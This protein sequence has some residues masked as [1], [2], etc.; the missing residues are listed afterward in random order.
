MRSPFQLLL[1]MLAATSVL[2]DSFSLPP[3]QIVTAHTTRSTVLNLVPEQGK[4]LVAA[5]TAASVKKEAAATTS[6]IHDD[7]NKKPGVAFV[8]SSIFSI[9][10]AILGRHPA[11]ALVDVPREQLPRDRRHEDVVLYPV[12][13]FRFVKGATGMSSNV[14]PTISKPACQLLHVPNQELYGWFTPACPLD[15]IYS[16]TYCNEPPKLMECK[17]K[18]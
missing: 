15:N 11:A 5:F 8:L 7:D 4:Q 14:L 9:P 6:T 3:H 2:I 17:P 13:G 16:D 1:L 10:G 12:V 18:D